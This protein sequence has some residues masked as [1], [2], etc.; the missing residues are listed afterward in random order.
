MKKITLFLKQKIASPAVLAAIA[1]AVILVCVLLIPP[2]IGMADNGDFFRII[3]GQGIY[4]LDRYEEDQFFNFFSSK[5]GIYQY[6]NEWGE[7]FFSSQNLYIRAGLFLNNIFARDKTIF[8]IRFMSVFLIIEMI[9]GLYLLVDYITWKKSRGEGL[10][11]AAM[12]V[13]IFADTAYTAYFNSF[14]GEGLVYVSALILV[15]SALL[16]TQKRYS[17]FLLFSLVLING[18]ILIFTKQQNATEGVPLFILCICIAFFFQIDNKNFRRF[19]VFG[20][21]LMAVCGVMMYVIIPE[22]FVRINQYHAM[23]RGAMMASEDPEETLDE[24]GINGQYT[25][26][27]GS[28]YYEK[29][30]AVDVEAEQLVEDFYDNYNF[31]SL[32]LHYLTHPKDLIYMLEEAA[33]NGYTIR[34]WEQGNY[35]RDSGRLPGAKTDFMTFYSRLKANAVPNTA[36]F[37]V[38]WMLVVCGLNI[39]DRQKLM[40]IICTIIMGLIQ[41]GTS[42]IGAGDADMAKHI[43]MYNVSFDLV[44]F[45]CFAPIATHMAGQMVKGILDFYRK[46]RKTAAAAL[47]ICLF[48]GTLSMNAEAAEAENDMP[49]EKALIISSQE[50]NTEHLELLAKAFGLEVTLITEYDYTKSSLELADYVITTSP[51]PAADILETGKKAI[52]LGDRFSEVQEADVTKYKNKTIRFSMKGYTGDEMFLE[53]FCLLNEGEGTTLGTVLLGTGEA[54]PFALI[55]DDGN[56][57]IPCYDSRNIGAAVLMGETIRILTERTAAGHT[58]FMIDEVYVFSDLNKICGWAEALHENG[59]PFLVRIMPLYQNL[60]YPAFLRFTQA[61]RYMQ[62]RGGTIVIH[63]PLVVTGHIEDEPIEMKMESFLNAL[64]QEAVLYREMKNTPYFFSVEELLQIIS[65]NKNFGELPFDN[66]TGVTPSQTEEEFDSCL[67]HINRK[68]LSFYDLQEE[69]EN[70]TLLYQEREI[71]QDFIYRE[72]QEAAFADFFDTSNQFLIVVVGVSLVV[73][74]IFLSIGR[75]WY[76]RKFYRKK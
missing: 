29:Y 12:A 37:A 46:K 38:I 48:V 67:A 66:M 20:A 9:L 63:E 28:I 42:I 1:G 50:E 45:V 69:Y 10:V 71:P 58:Y 59:I 30:P 32:T 24:F 21:V 65:S 49:G 41:I 4:K 5:Y 73:L 57:Y 47:L 70:T 7:V 75:K 68:W 26:L 11:L 36:G 13:F 15:A 64:T 76:R 52:F 72:K 62:S 44:T 27:D 25:V 53:E 33:K 34:P 17:P 6:Y 54:A 3:S 35:E 31:V 56:I 74:G 39:R 23:T 18:I 60:D 51:I 16:L 22:E 40:I 55:G 19:A 8:D 43:F 2:L 14:Y 61:L